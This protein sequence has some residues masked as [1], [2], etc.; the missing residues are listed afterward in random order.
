MRRELVT[1]VAAVAAVAWLLAAGM[2]LSG[3]GILG[4]LGCHWASCDDGCCDRGCDDP[5]CDQAGCCNSALCGLSAGGCLDRLKGCL[6][7]SDHCF[8]D[9]ISPMSNFVF[10]EDPRTLTELRPIF[11]SHQLPDSIG[12]GDVQLYAAE[13]RIALTDRLSLIASNWM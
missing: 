8:D 5:C 1:A 9:F 11:L 6:R 12:G 4:D 7:P 2:P 13:F 3:A 10:F